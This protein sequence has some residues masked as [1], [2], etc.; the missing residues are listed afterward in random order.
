MY[1]YLLHKIIL[2]FFFA[3]LL[4]AL[5]LSA[6][7][8]DIFIFHNPINEISLTES[9]QEL[10]LLIISLTFFSLARQYKNYR[11]GLFL[12][13]AFF[14]SLF[15][16]E[17]DFLFDPLPYISWFTFVLPLVLIALFYAL[18]N[19]ENCLNG[20]Q[21]FTKDSSFPL[22]F[23]GLLTVLVFSRIIGMNIIWQ[24]VLQQDY[25][26]VVKN[27][28]EEGSELFGYTLTLLATFK[29]KYK[30]TGKLFF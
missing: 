7:F 11:A 12:I 9:L 23:C 21:H 29:Y 16:R 2:P 8:I 24:N 22:M 1:K 28:I 17:L 15:L 13:S 20:L 19:Q 14:G 4:I 27:V 30:L 5:V 3:S 26:R 25:A 10:F 6:I 18:R